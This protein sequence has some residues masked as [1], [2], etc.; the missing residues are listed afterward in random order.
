MLRGV[1]G[2]GDGKGDGD[3]LGGLVRQGNFEEGEKEE[4]GVE[5]GGKEEDGVHGVKRERGVS[6]ECVE[7][8]RGVVGGGGWLLGGDGEGEGEGE[9]GEEGVKKAKGSKTRRRRRKLVIVDGFLLF[10]KSV[11]ES[12]KEL[13]DVKILLRARREDAKA[14]RERRNGYVTLEGF[15]E[16]PEGYFDGVVWPNYVR[17]HGALV[18]GEGEGEGEGV[19]SLDGQRVWLSDPGWGLEECLEWVVGVLGREGGGG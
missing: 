12:L 6:R 15:W 13:F 7:R 8:L 9:E 17:E 14:R 19:G 10:G 3:V 16:D 4:D 2:C 1:K 5:D 18:E 11:P